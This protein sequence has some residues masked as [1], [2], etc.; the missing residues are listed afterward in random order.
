MTGHHTADTTRAEAV[1]MTSDTAPSTFDE[2]LERYRAGAEAGTPEEL[3][4]LF[5]DD[6]LVDS[7]VP[8]WRFQIQGGEE[9]AERA[10]VLPRPG[11]FTTF[12]SEPTA[13]GV[14]V[15]FEW[16]CDTAGY[17]LVVRQLHAWRLVDGL[18]AEQLVFCAGV[19]DRQ[20]QELMA[21]KAPL[22]RP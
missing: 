16:R 6:A 21:V 8:N 2:L 19:W 17:E 3:V 14:L 9:A 18:I 20:L 12:T 5:H 4:E 15:Q 22:V 11:R 10:C 13:R 7:H 1:T